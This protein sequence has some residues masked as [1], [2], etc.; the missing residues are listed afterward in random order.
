[1]VFLSGAI[2]VPTLRQVCEDVA[3]LYSVEPTDYNRNPWL[4]RVKP[5]FNGQWF[6][7]R[8]NNQWNRIQYSSWHT[9]YAAEAALA[10]DMNNGYGLRYM[11]HPDH[12]NG[13]NISG[14]ITFPPGRVN[15]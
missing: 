14:V 6:E 1:M 10:T 4:W 8:R 13:I 12:P 9:R 7:V 5:W 15:Y 11:G 2:S 3:F